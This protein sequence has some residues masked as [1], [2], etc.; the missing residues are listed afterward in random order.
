MGASTW[1]FGSQRCRPYSGAFTMNAVSS[2][3][4][5]STLVQEVDRVGWVSSKVGR[6][7]VP[8]FTYRCMIV[9][10]RGSE[11]ISV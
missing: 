5:D 10:R 9:I 1:A 7:R 8:I 11:L 2:A 3:S 4:P 6:W